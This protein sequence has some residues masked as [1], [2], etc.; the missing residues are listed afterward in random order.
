MGGGGTRD[1]PLIPEFSVPN[2]NGPW[3]NP[4]LVQSPFRL[5]SANLTPDGPWQYATRGT[6]IERYALL[7]FGSGKANNRSRPVTTSGVIR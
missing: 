4:M 6:G 7:C 1:V 5:T 2:E 3:T